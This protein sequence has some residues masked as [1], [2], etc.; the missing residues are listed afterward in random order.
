MKPL[1]DLVTLRS[2]HAA[3][4]GLGGQVAMQQPGQLDRVARVA[5]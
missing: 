5:T 2:G 1:L 3:V 4:V